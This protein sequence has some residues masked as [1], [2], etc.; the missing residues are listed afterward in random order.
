[1]SWSNIE[2]SH[3]FNLTWILVLLDIYCVSISQIL[4][5]LN[6]KNSSFFL[7]IMLSANLFCLGEKSSKG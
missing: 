2:L 6:I 3:F 4:G 7:P 1:M 5:D